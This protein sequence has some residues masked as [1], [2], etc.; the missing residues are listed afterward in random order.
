MPSKKL[1]TPGSQPLAV[2]ETVV[3][4]KEGIFGPL[5]SLGKYGKNNTFELE[6][7]PSPNNRAELEEYAS[8]EPPKKEGYTFIC[9]GDCLVNSLDAKV[10][11]YRKIE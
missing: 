2:F 3:Q 8:E 9:K 6:I 4:Q 10:A 1:G 11:A 7:G 5:K